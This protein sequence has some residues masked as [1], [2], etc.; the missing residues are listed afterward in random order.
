[1]G[2]RW[3]LFVA[4]PIGDELRTVLAEAVDAWR[5]RPDLDGLRW[6]DPAGWHLTLAFLGATEPETVPGV[7]SAITSVTAS[8]APMT[9]EGGVLGGFPSARHAR[10]AWYGVDDPE[11]R[12]RGLASDVRAA[13]GVDRGAPFSPHLTVGRARGRAVDLRPWIAEVRP[14]V[15]R[16]DVRRVELLR[17]N[18]GP[19]PARYETIA[20]VE[21]E[22]VARV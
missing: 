3:R 13:I 5:Q 21:L 14:P 2:E 17:S 4:V 10:V 19:G 22:V 15:G 18:L 1:M 9:L 11:A 8:H 20:S 6:T 16:L 7:V 12:L